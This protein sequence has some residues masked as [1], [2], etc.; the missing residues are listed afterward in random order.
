MY[1]LHDFYSVP[2]IVKSNLYFWFS[3][4]LD[5]GNTS[6]WLAV[7]NLPWYT[8]LEYS[9]HPEW[10]RRILVHGWSHTCGPVFLCAV[11]SAHEVHSFTKPKAPIKAVYVA[12]SANYRWRL[13]SQRFVCARKRPTASPGDTPRDLQLSVEGIR[14]IVAS[15]FPN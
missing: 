11:V 2:F 13:H 8:V 5:I 12:L 1:W 9:Q 15:N 10:S 6:I 3:N 4:D 7:G 14:L